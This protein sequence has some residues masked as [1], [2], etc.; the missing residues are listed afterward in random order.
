MSD[1]YF[2]KAYGRL[3]EKADEGKLR[4][5]T[6]DSDEGTVVY[7][8]IQREVPLKI[9]HAPYYDIL[10]PYGYSGPLMTSVHAGKD[11]K[12]LAGGFDEAFQAYCDKERIVSEFIRFHPLAENAD[13]FQSVYELEHARDTVAT[14]LRDYADPFQ[15]EFSSS[16][17]NNVRRAFKKGVTYHVV[18]RPADLEAFKAVY[19]HT[20]ERTNAAAYYFFDDAY[21]AGLL[22][23]YRDQLAVVE[24]RHAGELLGASLV[25]LSGTWIHWHLSGT[26]QHTQQFAPDYVKAYAI[27]EWGKANGYDFIHHGGGRTAS[28]DDKLYKFKKQFGKNTSF[29]YY[30]AKK[31]RNPALFD[32]LCRQ[33]NS[34]QDTDFFPPYAKKAKYV[35]EEKTLKV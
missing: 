19:R 32:A 11:R 27:T 4:T 34:R 30:F 5:F 13:D 14:N 18:E 28:K 25:L 23:M 33:T 12:R 9:D 1:I 15:A 17:R 29:P 6:Y 21:F 20:M 8:F 22:A 26:Y 31:L 24:V 7:R 3:Y 16:T 2:D 10:T 35:G